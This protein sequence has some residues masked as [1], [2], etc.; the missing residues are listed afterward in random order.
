MPKAIQNSTRTAELIS[1]E[2]N[3][4]HQWA[5]FPHPHVNS[6]RLSSPEKFIIVVETLN[7]NL[8]LLTAELR[9]LPDNVFA[10]HIAQ[11]L[12][13]RSYSSATDHRYVYAFKKSHGIAINLHEPDFKKIEPLALTGVVSRAIIQA[14]SQQSNSSKTPGEL[15]QLKN[16]LIDR[17]STEWNQTCSV[18]QENRLSPGNEQSHNNYMPHIYRYINEVEGDIRRNRQQAITAFPLLQPLLL[19]S[20]VPEVRTAIDQG[21]SLTEALVRHFKARKSVIKLLANV[22]MNNIDYFAYKLDILVTLLKAI[23]PEWWPKTKE[24]WKQFVATVKAIN[25]I[26]KKPITLSAYWLRECAKNNYTPPTQEQESL[27][28]HAIATEQFI[29]TLMHALQWK[30]TGHFHELAQVPK[31]H[32]LVMAGDIVSEIKSQMGLE[33]FGVLALRYEDAHRRAIADFSDGTKLLKDAAWVSVVNTVCQY[34]DIFIHP[35]LNDSELRVEGNHMQ[36]CVKGYG[37]RCLQGKCQIWS[38]RNSLGKR[39]STVETILVLVT[40]RA[41]NLKIVQHKGI[42]NC[43]PE[44][45]IIQQVNAFFEQFS[46]QHEGIQS[47]QSWRKTV[48]R[49]SEQVK[50]INA[51]MGPVITALEEI[52][53]SRWGL[54]K[55]VATGVGHAKVTKSPD[56]ALKLSNR[57]ENLDAS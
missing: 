19:N 33:K 14:L 1:V 9:S 8:A 4:F 27:M 44:A 52:L 30:L 53:P 46:P 36:N 6:V 23:P 29:A 41:Y 25:A 24:A 7:G 38:I 57:T 22:E 37:A 15:V 12:D 32:P 55:L 21:T 50:L 20:S 18:F 11:L 42:D 56:C 49:N 34:E 39:Y 5:F 26:S 3:A 35:L 40:S 13:E 2:N 17:F 45:K 28:R 54:D 48:A 16:Q 51:Q 47:Y 31:I 10:N 43:K